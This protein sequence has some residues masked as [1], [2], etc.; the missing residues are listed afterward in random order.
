[1]AIAAFALPVRLLMMSP[2]DVRSP[3]NRELALSS[4]SSFSRPG[5]RVGART[6]SL[7]RLQ[8]LG[9]GADT[10][11]ALVIHMAPTSAKQETR[12]P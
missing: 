12:V 10:P 6:A 5:A 2:R 9:A 8:R 4:V 7:A 3:S 11:A 1:M